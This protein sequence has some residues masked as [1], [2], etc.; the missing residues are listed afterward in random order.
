MHDID[1]AIEQMEAMKMKIVLL[2]D[3]KGNF[4]PYYKTLRIPI[5]KYSTQYNL[6]RNFAIHQVMH[7]YTMNF[8][9]DNIFVY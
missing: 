8:C 7:Y 3:Y 9:V 5:I 2:Q 4:I 1:I 6:V